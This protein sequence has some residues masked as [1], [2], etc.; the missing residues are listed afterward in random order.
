MCHLQRSE[1]FRALPSVT[2]GR[3]DEGRVDSRA[4]G[5]VS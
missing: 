5:D 3:H 2:E 4:G 1:V